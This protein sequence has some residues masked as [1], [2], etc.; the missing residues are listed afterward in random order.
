MSA[1]LEARDNV[2]TRALT[3]IREL[4]QT[5]ERS[6]RARTEPIAVVGMACRLPGANGPDAFWELLRTG[7]DAVTEMP[8]ARWDVDAFYSPDPNAP[9]K[10]YAKRGGFVEDVDSFDAAFFGISPREA[11]HMDPQQRMFLEV[12]WE[13]LE[14]AG[15][16]ADQLAGSQTGVFVGVTGFDYSQRAMQHLP[17]AELD[18]Y[19]LTGG[20]STFA[21]GR[22]AYWLGL[23]GPSLSI[24]T[25]CSSS[26][27][28]VHLA[29]QS[30]RAG[31]CT[32]ALAGGVNAL[33]A[34]E[35]FVVLSKA[36]MLSPDGRC[37]AF[38]AS[39]DGYV[40]SEGCGVVVLKRLSSALA[41]NDRVL[42]VIRGS[43]VNQD[44]RSSGITVPNGNAQQAVIRQALAN[45]GVP[46]ARVGYV[47]THGTGTALGDPIEVRAL[48]AVLGADRPADSPVVLG[49]AKAAVGHLESAAGVTGLIKAIL[50]LRN[51]Q[52]PPLAHL[53]E[54]N[55]EIKADT[56]PVSLPTT[57]T[58]WPR[59]AEPRVAGVSSFGASGTNTHVIV[60]EAPAA[61]PRRPEHDHAMERPEHVVT[62]S[63]RTDAALG[64][65]AGRYVEALAAAEL[66]LGDLAFTAN[67]GRAP[68]AQ[69]LAVRAGSVAELRD[70]LG[71]HLAGE[72]LSDVWA[73]TVKGRTRP[74]VAFLF[75]GQGSQYAGMARELYDT[76]PGVRADLDRCDRVLRDH[77]D[78]PLLSVLFGE[79]SGEDGDA[80]LIDQTRYTQPALFAVEYAVARLWMRWGVEPA[81]M[82]GHSV[83]EYAAA[84][85]AGVF[86]LEEGLAL[87]AERARLMDEL[88][89]G[90]AMA[91]VFAAPAAVAAAIRG[92][93]DG[94]SVA[95]VN[96]P[97]HVVVAGARA[98]LDEVLEQLAAAGVRTKR[99]VV[100]HAFHSPLL[101]PMLS[102]LEKRAAQVRYQAPA[103]PLVSNL[104]GDWVDAETFDAAY[105]RDHARLPV[106]FADGVARLVELGVQAFV[107]VGPAAQLCGI[108]KKNFPAAGQRLLLG[109]L[110]KSHGDWRTLLRSLGELSVTG[111][112]I[113]W[114]GFDQAYPRR[115]VTLPTYPFER[116]RHWLAVSAKPR[117]AAA[118][119]ERSPVDPS[120]TLLGERLPSPLDVAQFHAELTTAAHPGLADC[121]AGDVAVVNAGFYLESVV[122]AAEALQGTAVVRIDNIVMPHALL[123]PPDGRLTTQLVVTPAGERSAFTYHRRQTGDT[124]EW[125]LHAQ[126]A[127]STKVPAPV[128]IEPAELDAIIARCDI[129]IAGTA[130]YRSLWQR[131]VHLGP[132]AQWLARVA[133][134]DGE[135]LAWVRT[136]DEAEAENGYHLHPGIVDSALQSLFACLPASWPQDI[137]LMLL[138]IG[139]YSFYGHDGGPLLCHTV[140][141]GKLEQSGTLAAEVTLVTLDGRCVAR[142]RD[143]HMKAT[144]HETMIQAIKA[145][146]RPRA[147]MAINPVTAAAGAAPGASLADL[148][149]QGEE[150]AAPRV[151]AVLAESVAAVLGSASADI[152]PDCS[153]SELGMDSLLAVELK[154]MISTALG[155]TL[156][157]ALFLDAS[158]VSDL[159]EAIIA[160][161]RPAAS[162]AA[163]V[164]AVAA[165]PAGVERVGP[166]GMRIVEHG[167]GEPVVFVHGGAFGGPESWQTQLPLAAR[168]RLV[169]VSR[170]NYDNSP[171]S[172]REDFA[173]DGRLLA[174]LLDELP[175]GG[176]HLVAQSY[177]TL[178]AM[179]AAAQRPEA[180]RSLTMIESAASA[181][182]R[183]T[184]AVD[185]YER[186]MRELAAAPPADP[187]EF[188]RA[189][190]A[191][192]EPQAK[193]PTPIPA[194]L[195]AFAARTLKATRWPWEAEVPTEPLRAAGFPT[196]VVSGGQRRFFEDISDALAAQ[197]GGQR[198]VVAGGHGTQNAGTPFN[199]VLE[200]FLN[201]ARSSR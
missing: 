4:R 143:V 146:P 69:R 149:S 122:Q 104:T 169:I 27:V 87:V 152:D 129:K 85:V 139:E 10:T 155:L 200:D 64:A 35:A 94:L 2:V 22:L 96:G 198:A 180:V 21:A 185:E 71:R 39:A 54:V 92:H 153:L 134:R 123:V 125:A 76:E 163:G 47:E 75:T 119:A 66:P 106:R 67:T 65:L 176:A 181:V 14:N 158:T 74:K 160:A 50:T 171:A 61:G 55:P 133:R 105:F 101:E 130:F 196:L 141:T 72:R 194:S 5:L 174:E 23:Q 84:C 183:G 12:S 16:P 7:A 165:A 162:G 107:E 201:Q 103:I 189:M 34:P 26:L 53:R 80:G 111:A 19:I 193:F 131:H 97:Q 73:G 102:G 108:M 184:P 31:D 113:D 59:G 15:L 145:P 3:E 166:G 140:V 33:L 30:L 115:R 195:R 32:S 51:E 38:D 68:F 148:L 82:L 136:P 191:I 150:S 182:A 161:A 62:L 28:A 147:K 63:A 156:P 117:P 175:A 46:A 172:E 170:L 58:P 116:K 157:A 114:K 177:G 173:E 37:K 29:V 128:G 109:S 49:A 78:Q 95:A 8:S 98:A 9:G 151:R 99:L 25:A 118:S 159:G 86:S 167:S 52:I 13:A 126:G 154:D 199:T 187:D 137:V 1:S 24:D 178:G 100:S 60:E 192:I 120:P 20:A 88:P 142:M 110:R 124:G 17:P 40:R 91:A 112:E 43:A 179:L 41:D 83:G 70:L 127:F 197:L 79:G 93:E 90:G 144:G 81:A 168:W 48:S 42:A 164:A 138:E 186:A 11:A 89:A 188:F 121:V 77:L 44:G 6:E 135:A 132:S 57:L 45:A 56:L 190:F 36:K 18:G